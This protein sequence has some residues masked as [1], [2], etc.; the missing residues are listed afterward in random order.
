MRFHMEHFWV[1]QDWISELSDQDVQQFT[2]HI[3]TKGTSF[4]IK[5]EDEKLL[6]YMIL[7]WGNLIDNRNE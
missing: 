5:C 3:V 1:I 6:N 2:T 4:V 7:R